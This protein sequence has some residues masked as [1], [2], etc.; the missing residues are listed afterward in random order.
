M[1]FS[2]SKRARTARDT[3]TAFSPGF[4]VTSMVTA[5]IA[6]PDAGLAASALGCAAPSMNHT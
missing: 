5:G 1:L 6:L 3:S 2:V 4:L